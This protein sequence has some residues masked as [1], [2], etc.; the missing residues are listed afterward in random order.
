MPAAS[1]APPS[2]ALA[3]GPAWTRSPPWTSPPQG[4]PAK[5]SLPQNQE[6][7]WRRLGISGWS[8]V[9][10][11][12]KTAASEITILGTHMRTCLLKRRAAAG[13]ERKQLDAF[14]EGSTG[15]TQST[16][17]GTCPSP[18]QS[19][20]LL[21]PKLDFP[22]GCAHVNTHPHMCGCTHVCAHKPHPTCVHANTPYVCYRLRDADIHRR[23]HI[24]PQHLC[25]HVHMYTHRNI[26]PPPMF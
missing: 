9:C 23:T 5:R 10:S 4:P 25:P 15:G 3:L 12:P 13:S 20:F 2:S 1:T 17:G 7:C 24:Y 6:P 22:A 16:W 26:S 8:E 18:P 19:L 14:N 21:P 11:A